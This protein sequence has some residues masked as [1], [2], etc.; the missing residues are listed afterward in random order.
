MFINVEWRERME[1]MERIENMAQ[2]IYVLIADERVEGLEEEE[3]SDALEEA[4]QESIGMARIFWKQ[5]EEEQVKL[6]ERGL[7]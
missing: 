3:R 1:R 6:E 2:A 4:A 5:W 7:L